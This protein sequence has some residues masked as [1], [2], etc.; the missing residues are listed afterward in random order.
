ML[1]IYTGTCKVYLQE[2]SERNS[3]DPGVCTF[4]TL[5]LAIETRAPK[6]STNGNI[7]AEELDK[8]VIT[9][10]SKAYTGET[11]SN[12][13]YIKRNLGGNKVFKCDRSELQINRNLNGT[14]EIFLR[15]LCDGVL[16]M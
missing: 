14:L 12:C 5:Q 10:V 2:P 16:I 11:C 13:E 7:D 4:L 8:I 6:E 9:S 1:D 3:C 15:A